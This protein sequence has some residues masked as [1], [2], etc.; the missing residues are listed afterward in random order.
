MVTL[1]FFINLISVL[2]DTGSVAEDAILVQANYYKTSGFPD[3]ALMVL[4]EGYQKFRSPNLLKEIIVL[5]FQSSEYESTVKYG[6]EYLKRF[7][8]D[9]LVL[10]LLTRSF[11]ALEDTQSAIKTSMK[12]LDL[13]PDDLGAIHLAA[14]IFDIYGSPR[15]ALRLYRRL[16]ILKPDSLPFFRDY[17]ALLVR[18]NMFDEAMTLLNKWYDK[19][20][21]DPKVELSYA[22]LLEK[23]GNDSTA[24]IHYSRSNMLRPSP[25]V[26]YHMAQILINRAKYQDALAV[27][28]LSKSINPIDPEA[29]K[30]L[31][32]V[33]Y[34]LHSDSL[35]LD[36]LLA[37]LALKS[38]D[39]ETH[40][41]L[42]RV[43]RRI[44][45]EESAYKHAKVSYELGKNPEYGLYLAYLEIIR[46]RPKAAIELL[47]ELNLDDRAHTHTLL[48]FAYRLLNDTTRALYELEQAVKL[49]PNDPKRKRDLVSLYLSTGRDSQAIYLLEDIRKSGMATREDLMNLALIYAKYN[50]YHKADTIYQTL[51]QMDSL[52]ATLL[53]NW[54]YTLAESGMNLALAKTLVRKALELDPDNPIFLDSMGWVYF[55]LDSID[56]AYYYIKRAID[57]GVNDPEILYHMGV[58]LNK[59]GK[60]KE[61]LKY[62]K[63]ALQLNPKDEKILQEIENTKINRDNG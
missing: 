61:A 27:L 28:T 55:M 57:L 26:V 54:G 53:N 9:S 30:L 45:L 21:P 58:V 17:L 16:Y 33:Y 51:Y 50:R 29:R 32:I 1:L 47:K 5:E 34:Y 39:P 10:N 56:F 4:Q 63:K 60:P 31:G 20:P 24:L 25:R 37:S 62:L 13:Y 48:G 41:Y 6:R 3:S 35:A 40:Y 2:P 19:L 14:N 44:G 49:A 12:Y 43:M 52:D 8:P 38:D 42:A 18:E 11:V 23:M 46:N 36:E 7:K 22:T 59:L 15:K